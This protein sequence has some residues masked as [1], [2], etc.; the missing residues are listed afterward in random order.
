LAIN[1]S[2]AFVRVATLPLITHKTPTTPPTPFPP[3]PLL[4]ARMSVSGENLYYYGGGIFSFESHN[5]GEH[6]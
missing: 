4:G 5:S 3:R 2:F 1:E 6:P